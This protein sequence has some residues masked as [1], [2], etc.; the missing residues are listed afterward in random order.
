AFRGKMEIVAKTFCQNPALYA[1]ILAMNPENERL[2]DAYE[3]NVGILKDMIRGR[4]VERV[5]DVIERHAPL[6]RDIIK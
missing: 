6:F 4:D 2:V 5:A 3:R 1:D